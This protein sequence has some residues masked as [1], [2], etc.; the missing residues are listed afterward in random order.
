MGFWVILGMAVALSMDAFAVSISAGIVLPKVTG[1]H[2]FRMAFHF[3]LFQFLMPLIGWLLGRLVVDYIS[4]FD[5]W[6][7]F[8]LLSFVGGKMIF[9]AFEKESTQD[10]ERKDPTR[11][12]SLILLSVATSIDA[13][14]VGLSIGCQEP[15]QGVLVP[16]TAIGL[17]CAA[18]SAVG[19]F[20]GKRVGV[21]LGKRAEFVGGLILIGIGTNI[22][23][24]HL[25]H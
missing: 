11:G 4:H 21:L 14:A 20:L 18:I 2:L 25:S 7:A 6:V 23:F 13:L 22:L 5:H 24:N 15:R 12:W 8:G 3:G 1:R 9:E 17:V 10:D 16:A 19:M